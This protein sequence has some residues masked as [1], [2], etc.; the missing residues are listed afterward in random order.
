MSIANHTAKECKVESCDRDVYARGCCHKHYQRLRRNGDPLIKNKI[1]AIKTCKIDGCSSKGSARGL[2]GKHY[3]RLKRHGDPLYKRQ[4]TTACKTNCR[5]GS[6]NNRKAPTAVCKAENCDDGKIKGLGYCNKHY[7]RL[8]RHGS[9]FS[10]GCDRIYGDDD[11]RFESYIERI[12]YSACHYWVGLLNSAGYGRINIG[13]AVQLAPRYAYE[14]ANGPIPDGMVVRHTCDTP[15]CVNPGHLIAG[16][17][18]DNSRDMVVR[19]R[20][21]GAKLTEADVLA[22]RASSE[23]SSVLGRRYR[24][25]G[26]TINCA[27]A[28]QT[29]RHI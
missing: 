16:T 20:S 17:P 23:P 8:R 7:L 21:G 19:G 11:A 10:G 25:T 22:I 6:H 29:W 13:G 2:C 18:A 15:A 14:Q 27:K 3:N 28:R 26:G 12:P 5:G 9:P 4:A 24:V 1:N